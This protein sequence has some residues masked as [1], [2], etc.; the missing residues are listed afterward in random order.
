VKA[1]ILAGGRGARLQP[2]TKVIPKPLM[3]VG[4]YPIAE[5]L[6]RQLKHAG[7]DHVILAV[8]HMSGLL[9]AFF[10]DGDRLGMRIEYS[11]E[12]QPLGT[13]G[14]I[15]AVIDELGEHF[16]VT[17]GDLLTTLD[18]GA[19][20]RDHMASGAAATI[21]LY[22]RE[23]KIDFGVVDFTEDCRLERYREKPV[24]SFEV[25]MGVN[26]LRASAVRPY[27]LP[28]GYLDI[29]DLMTQLVADG[30]IVRGYR[31]ECY[32]LDIGRVEDYHVATQVF[33]ENRDKFLP[34]LPGLS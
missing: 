9:Q 27:L 26:V 18:F 24:F 17:N 2:Y 11:F 8:G 31:S 32:W 23:V 10:G 15:G 4:D 20:Y 12:D 7:V 22:R 33:E 3:P 19:M 5:I 30:H 16:I 28:G 29:P 14:P 1:L 21:G 25:S 13:A 6:L 34:A